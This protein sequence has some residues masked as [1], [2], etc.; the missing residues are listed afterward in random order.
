MCVVF[1]I[2]LKHTIN[3]LK[4]SLVIWGVWLIWVISN[5]KW[6]QYLWANKNTYTHQNPTVPLVW[7]ATGLINSLPYFIPVNSPV[8]CHQA[9]LFHPEQ[10]TPMNGHTEESDQITAPGMTLGWV[11]GFCRTEDLA[12]V[13]CRGRM[14]CLGS[15][16]PWSEHLPVSFCSS[17]QTRSKQDS[18]IRKACR[19][20][21]LTA[22]VACSTNFESVE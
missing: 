19:I 1:K 3:K 10:G 2:Y 6:R 12:A 18:G 8:L 5:K 16:A 13:P 11:S 20:S 21:S 17:A 15:A 7:T 22:Q 14:W 9:E 4:I